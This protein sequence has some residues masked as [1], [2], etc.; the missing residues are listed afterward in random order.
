MSTSPARTASPAVPGRP[1]IV[2]SVLE[3]DSVPTVGL[4]TVHGRQLPDVDATVLATV[5]RPS[6]RVGSSVIVNSR[7]TLAP[8]ATV[9]VWV[10]GVAAAAPVAHDQPSATPV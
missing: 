2:V 7:S 1:L 6:G 10:H 3:T 5:C 9:S 4:T 8:G